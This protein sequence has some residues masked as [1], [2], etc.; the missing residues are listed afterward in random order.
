MEAI[1]NYLHTFQANFQYFIFITFDAIWEHYE[2]KPELE[3][4]EKEKAE[5]DEKY[6]D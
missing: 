1:I 3:L 4:S 6:E 2:I 5:V